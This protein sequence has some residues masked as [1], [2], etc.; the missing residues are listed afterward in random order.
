M[1]CNNNNKKN[2]NESTVHDVI[3]LLVSETL[4]SDVQ[5]RIV[6]CIFG[7]CDLLFRMGI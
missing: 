6:V 1:T 5:S 4:S 3:V 7:M 2:S